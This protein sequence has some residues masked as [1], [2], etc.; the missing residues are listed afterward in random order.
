MTTNTILLIV[1]GL[2]ALALTAGFVR[3]LGMGFRYVSDKPE[4]RDD[5]VDRA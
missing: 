1:L 2:I 5:S 3:L 4:E